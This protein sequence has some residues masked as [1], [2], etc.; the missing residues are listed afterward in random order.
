MKGE[1]KKKNKKWWQPD[2][3]LG[4]KISLQVLHQVLNCRL[5]VHTGLDAPGG[6]H[7]CIDLQKLKDAQQQEI[8]CCPV[9]SWGLSLPKGIEVSH[10]RLLPG[11]RV[12]GALVLAPMAHRLLP[13]VPEGC[14]T[15]A[16]YQDPFG[17]S[18]LP[19][20]PILTVFPRILRLHCPS[21]ESALFPC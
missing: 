11:S 21:C 5:P 8:S 20:A 15:P 6:R 12:K 9:P 4:A 7:G 19:S 17:M 14:S 16:L 2:L 3:Q 18:F 13:N 10:L 1:K